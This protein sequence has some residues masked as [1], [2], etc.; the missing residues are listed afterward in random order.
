MARLYSP[1]M[2][3]PLTCDMKCSLFSLRPLTNRTLIRST[4]IAMTTVDIMRLTYIGQPPASNACFNPCIMTQ[5]L[6]LMI[7]ARSAAIG[8]DQH[9]LELRVFRLPGGIH[10]LRQQWEGDV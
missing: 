4:M 9:E 8:L 10:G 7:R 1:L 3:R 2:M 5:T 6:L